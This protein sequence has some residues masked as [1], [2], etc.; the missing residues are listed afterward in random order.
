[1]VL[2]HFCVALSLGRLESRYRS[3]G[4]VQVLG[5]SVVRDGDSTGDSYFDAGE[6]LDDLHRSLG[7][8]FSSRY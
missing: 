5:G 3:H 2:Q 4:F 7:C 8:L 1:M 6:G